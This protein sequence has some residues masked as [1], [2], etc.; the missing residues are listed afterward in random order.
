MARETRDW[1]S[2]EV[3]VHWAA[4][5]ERPLWGRGEGVKVRG[6]GARREGMR[7]D[8]RE[9]GAG[10]GGIGEG[11]TGEGGAD[12]FGSDERGSCGEDRGGGLA[13][14]EMAPKSGRGCSSAGVWLIGV[15][16]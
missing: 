3:K 12:S 16:V 13:G 11:G 1:S 5:R 15:V 14:E 2:V 10:E 7:E 6:G 8:L 4:W 9:E